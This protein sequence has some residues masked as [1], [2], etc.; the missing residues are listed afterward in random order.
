MYEE[1]TVSTN[2]FFH[3]ENRWLTVPTT[4]NNRPPPNAGYTIIDYR[5]PEVK[6]KI[7]LE[8]IRLTSDFQVGH[9]LVY[10]MTECHG[11]IFLHPHPENL[12]RIP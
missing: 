1:S 7:L 5:L 6:A 9:V 2:C 8:K 12:S 10:D 3:F 11:E 4:K